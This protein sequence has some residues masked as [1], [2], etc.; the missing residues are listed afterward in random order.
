MALNVHLQLPGNHR[1]NLLHEILQLARVIDN[2]R[3]RSGWLDI[4]LNLGRPPTSEGKERGRCCLKREAKAAHITRNVPCLYAATH[5]DRAGRGSLRLHVVRQQLAGLSVG[6]ERVPAVA[7]G[8]CW[9]LC[10]PACDC[11]AIGHRSL[12]TPPARG[13][14]DR[15]HA[16]V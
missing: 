3:L 6:V 7:G 9:R 10:R 15:R 11:L 1:F 12:F 16:R 5:P 2:Q 8:R 14:A 4:S 13:E